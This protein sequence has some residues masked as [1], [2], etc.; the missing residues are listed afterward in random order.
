MVRGSHRSPLSVDEDQY[1]RGFALPAYLVASSVEC[2]ASR[3]PKSMRFE[4]PSRMG[5]AFGSRAAASGAPVQPT[6]SEIRGGGA[7]PVA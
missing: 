4:A 6:S 7:A 3:R 2:F 1:L 5:S